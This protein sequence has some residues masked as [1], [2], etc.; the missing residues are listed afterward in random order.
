MARISVA[1]SE[2]KFPTTKV[3]GLYKSVYDFHFELSC[4]RCRKI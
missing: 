3:V 2:K 1:G 4:W